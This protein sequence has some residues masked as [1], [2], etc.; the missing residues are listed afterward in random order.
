MTHDRILEPFHRV[1]E[2]SLKVEKCFQNFKSYQYLLEI[3]GVFHR[4][5]FQQQV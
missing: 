3:L 4:S 1:H 5:V 2:K